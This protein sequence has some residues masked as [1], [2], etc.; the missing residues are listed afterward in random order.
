[1]EKDLNLSVAA[2]TYYLCTLVGIPVEMTR[3]SD[4]A[5]YDLYGDLDS[6][7]GKKKTYDLKNRVRFVKEEGGGVY[8]GIH[9]NK[10]PDPKYSGLQVYY[11]P[12][13]GA[14][15]EFANIIRTS[16]K[17][18]LQPENERETKRAT[19]AIYV[20]DRITVPA[21]L[22][23]CGFVSNPDELSLLCNPG[24]RLRL[25]AMLTSSASRFELGR[26]Y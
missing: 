5:L 22:V 12:N 7:G 24:Y 1:M 10:F 11:S 23:E 8:L 15:E 4:T 26:G 25:A 13:D 20:L 14:S 9:M 18:Y 6:Y 16:S 21:V 17:E 19:S 2:N 3:K